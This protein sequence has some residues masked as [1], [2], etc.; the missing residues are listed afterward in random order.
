MDDRK[1]S[2]RVEVSPWAPGLAVGPILAPFL[3]QAETGAWAGASKSMDQA[4]RLL[5]LTQGTRGRVNTR[6]PQ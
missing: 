1:S 5:I 4:G 6:E 2:F 3:P